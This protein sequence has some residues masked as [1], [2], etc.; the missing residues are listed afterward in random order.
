MQSNHHKEQESDPT[1]TSHTFKQKHLQDEKERNKMLQEIEENKMFI[2]LYI[3]EED[4]SQEDTM[5]LGVAT[6]MAHITN[7]TNCIDYI[8]NKFHCIFT[9][10]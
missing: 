4:I 5:M 9:T 2:N 10:K 6:D 8:N 1:S 3:K 7:K